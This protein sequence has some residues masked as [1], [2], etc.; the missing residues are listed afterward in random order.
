MKDSALEGAGARERRICR[1]AACASVVLALATA[2]PGAR[3]QPADAAAEAAATARELF[4]Q[5]EHAYTAEEYAKAV[6]LLRRAYALAPR[7]AFLFNIAQAQRKLGQCDAARTSYQDYLL[8]ETNPAH[9]ERVERILRDMPSCDAQAATVPAAEP[10][11]P[12]KKGITEVTAPRPAPAPRD[13]VTPRNAPADQAPGAGVEIAKWSLLG[14]G[15]VSAGL[16]AYFAL[17]ARGAS[18]DLEHASVWSSDESE[19][20][21]RGKR[22]T[23]LAWVCAGAGFSLLGAGLTLHFLSEPDRR[24]SVAG[25]ELAPLAGGARAS[26]TGRF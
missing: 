24:R 3:A 23:T 9:R 16:A 19:R 11:Q 5:A 6:N 22:S 15:T 1:A 14:A 25:L 20:E 4:V 17:D 10:P 13:A 2:A 26:F 7:P 8:R 21:A 18:D 12:E